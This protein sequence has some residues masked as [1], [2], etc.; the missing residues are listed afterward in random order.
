MKTNKTK[1]TVLNAQTIESLNK[2]LNVLKAK[3]ETSLKADIARAKALYK[4]KSEELYK[5]D[6]ASAERSF[7]EWYTVT[8]DGTI[9]GVTYKSACI[10]INTY[11]NVWTDKNLSD[12]PLA[13]A[14][15]LASVC[16]TEEGKKSVKALKAKG[17]IT[18][19][20]TQNAINDLLKAEGLV[21]AKNAVESAPAPHSDDVVSEELKT[22]LALVNAYLVNNC[23]DKNILSQWDIIL[24]ANK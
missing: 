5:C 18:P 22:A 10:L 15:R 6:T 1:V 9:Y 7:K 17:K 14:C 13:T 2:E 3:S 20:M 12:M 11:A 16:K 24:N 21:K 8:R 19:T 4:I 23:K